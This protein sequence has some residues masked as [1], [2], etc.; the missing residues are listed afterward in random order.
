[1]SARIAVARELSIASASLLSFAQDQ[2]VP[3]LKKRLD[4]VHELEQRLGGAG[5]DDAQLMEEI[6]GLCH[7]LRNEVH[8]LN[9]RAELRGLL[10]GQDAAFLPVRETGS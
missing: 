2:R 1:M 5:E 6:V 4:R 3:R 10:E 9:M 7:D 8:V